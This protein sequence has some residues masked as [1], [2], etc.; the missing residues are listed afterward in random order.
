MTKR[1]ACA[2]AVGLAIGGCGVGSAP[3]G[4]GGRGGGAG[5]HAGGSVNGTGGH[6]GGGQSGSTASGGTAGAGSGGAGGSAGAGASQGGHGVEQAGGPSGAA[7]ASGG[8]Q[9]SGGAAGGA[10]IPGSGGVPGIGGAHGGAGGVATGGAVGQGG[11]A[12]SAGGHGGTAGAANGGTAGGNAGTPGTGGAGG[13][14]GATQP[15]GELSVCSQFRARTGGRS[16]T[17][18]LDLGHTTPI[19]VVRVA[20][21]RIVTHDTSG[22]YYLWNSGTGNAVLSGEAVTSVDLA[23]AVLAVTNS[24]TAADVRSATDGHVLSSLTLPNGP[25]N[26]GPAGAYVWSA[27]TSALRAWTPAGAMVVDV[28]GDYSTAHIAAV[29]TELRVALGPAGAGVI[30]RV[31]IGTSART[32]TAFNGSFANWFDDGERFLAHIG[33]T[34]FVDALD[35]SQLQ[36][37]AFP[38]GAW[39]TAGGWGNYFWTAP[40]TGT[41]YTVGSSTPLDTPPLIAD[42]S[43]DV[44]GHLVFSLSGAVLWTVSTTSVSRVNWTFLG[45]PSQI[46]VSP[47]GHWAIGTAE[48]LVFDGRSA[49]PRSSFSCG[50]VLSI[51]GAPTG[52]TAVSVST[53]QIVMTKVGAAGPAFTSYRLVVPEGVAVGN[54]ELSFDGQELATSS[55]MNYA[56][57]SAGTFAQLRL[58]ALPAGTTIWSMAATIGTGLERLRVA[59]GGGLLSCT[60]DIMPGLRMGTFVV[61]PQTSTLVYRTTDLDGPELPLLAPGGQLFAIVGAV[62][63][64]T[65]I[66]KRDGTLVTAVAGQG[67]VWMDD[68]R[69]L[70]IEQVNTPTSHNELHLY[71][72]NGVS[73]GA[74]VTTSSPG[75]GNVKVVGTDGVY[76]TSDNSIYS[77][78]TGAQTWTGSFPASLGGFNRDD[79]PRRGS[80]AAGY[81]VYPSGHEVIAEPY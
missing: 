36:V 63:P 20:G 30:E 62:S 74:G 46:G 38:S 64:G 39:M 19:D 11:T 23:G 76:A 43:S 54:V 59:G 37:I 25:L 58:L 79:D 22:H 72:G 5:G 56:V 52:D 70:V 57:S 27:G 14:G 8:T 65:R 51:D 73:L 71:D 45:A 24:P 13:N 75:M 21:D 32:T 18:S 49:L 78:T 35:G 34:V 26:V 81:V 44:P 60:T 50:K 33:D 40:G 47:E 41:V 31:A 10:G 61:S 6:G 4:N 9:G 1:F 69:L 29:G 66:Y 17:L 53:G 80:V 2:L 7:G 15:P 28:A 12:G 77:V 68:N 55:V 16:G 42:S 3:S 67:L 48:G